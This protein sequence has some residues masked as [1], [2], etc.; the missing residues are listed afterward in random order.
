MEN[1]REPVTTL[2]WFN[3]DLRLDDNP[4]LD[5][6]IC[7]ASTLLCLYCHDPAVYGVDT[8][9]TERQGDL[10]QRFIEHSQDQH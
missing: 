7:G 10:R 2:Y 6:A 3:Q 9:G 1:S 4:A 8:F 5:L